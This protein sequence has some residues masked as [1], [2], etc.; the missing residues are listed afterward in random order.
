MPEMVAER[1]RLVIVNLQSTPLDNVAAMRINAKCDDVMTAVMKKL[2]IDIPEF[3]LRRFVK[4]TTTP[5]KDK[6]N[7]LVEGVDVDGIPA[8]I[9]KTVGVGFSQ[10]C[11]LKNRDYELKQEPFTLSGPLKAFA[12]AKDAASMQVKFSFYAHYKEPSLSVEFPIVTD[13][14]DSKT[15]ML[16][17]NPFNGKWNDPIDVVKWRASLADASKDSKEFKTEQ[18]ETIM[19]VDEM[20]AEMEK[21]GFT[22][23]V[24]LKALKA[25]NGAFQ[26]ALDSLKASKSAPTQ[27]KA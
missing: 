10:A 19:S 22:V 26:P 27:S 24:A 5:A 15:F 2:S 12:D 9:F 13:K 18:K 21:L 20:V 8:S 4:I 16:E 17:Y 3:R 23:A 11:P 7:I 25:S 6:L 1:H 14:A